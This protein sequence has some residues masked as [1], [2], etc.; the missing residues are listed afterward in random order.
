MS[1]GSAETGD[2]VAKPTDPRVASGQEKLVRA[3]GEMFL[4]R[5][6]WH[7]GVLAPQL[8]P[9]TVFRHLGWA[10]VKHRSNYKTQDAG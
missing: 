10:W 9:F 1:Q 3:Q 5:C 4:G 6:P 2:P 7:I 8:R